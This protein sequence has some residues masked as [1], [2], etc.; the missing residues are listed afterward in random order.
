MVERERR[1]RAFWL[2]HVR[3][4]EESEQTI[5]AYA[6]AHDVSADMLYRWRS[7][8]RSEGLLAAATP[9]LDDDEGVSGFVRAS[10]TKHDAGETITVAFPNGCRVELAC[11]C[12]SETLAPRCC[13]GWP[14]FE[15]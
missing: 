15:F 3:G 8:L 12:D 9:A 6:K 1:S 14:R 7:Q 11:G 5:A 13:A 4:A 10:V 2:S